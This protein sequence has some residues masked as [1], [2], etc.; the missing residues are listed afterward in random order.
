MVGIEHRVVVA[1]D[2]LPAAAVAELLGVA[3]RGEAAEGG[4]VAL[5]VRRPV[6]AEHVQHDDEGAAVRSEEHTSELQYLSR[7]SYAGFGLKK[8]RIYKKMTSTCQITRLN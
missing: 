5:V 6:V 7:H 3:G 4:R 1:V 2:D 8:K